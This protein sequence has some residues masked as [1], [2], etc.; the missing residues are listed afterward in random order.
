MNHHI[1]IAAIYF[2]LKHSMWDFRL[3]KS[4]LLLSLSTLH[5]T[6]PMY[7][8]SQCQ[9]F[10]D[11]LQEFLGARHMMGM[12]ALRFVWTCCVALSGQAKHR[13]WSLLAWAILVYESAQFDLFFIRAILIIFHVCR[14]VGAL[15]IVRH[16]V[17]TRE[18]TKN[19]ATN[20]RHMKFD[21]IT[22]GYRILN[23]PVQSWLRYIREGLC[24]S[25]T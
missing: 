3:F 23:T 13:T 20:L 12:T 21:D 11:S 2:S 17:N 16:N 18:I 14:V 7:C 15:W 9:S 5:F 19:R 4:E 6:H 25:S 22:R 10:S 1:R 8:R 24:L